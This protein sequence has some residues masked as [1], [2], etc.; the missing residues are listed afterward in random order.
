MVANVQLKIKHARPTIVRVSRTVSTVKSID[1]RPSTIR[2]GAIRKNAKTH[3]DLENSICVWSRSTKKRCLV[4]RYEIW[5]RV[6]VWWIVAVVVVVAVAIRTPKTNCR[7]VPNRR[8]KGHHKKSH[9]ERNGSRVT[10]RTKGKNKNK[11]SIF[12][13]THHPK[14]TL[15]VEYFNAYNQVS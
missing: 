10:V 6:V 2:V 11:S 9:D 13:S 3:S 15:I 5:T 14:Q 7:W 1:S 12:L 4:E 8:V